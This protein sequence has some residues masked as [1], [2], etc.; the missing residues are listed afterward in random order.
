MLARIAAGARYS[1]LIGFLATVLA[2]VIGVFLGIQ[3]QCE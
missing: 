3:A 1:L 2:G